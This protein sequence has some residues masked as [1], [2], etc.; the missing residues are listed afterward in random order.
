[1]P[2]TQSEAVC[3]V[4]APSCTIFVD[5]FGIMIWVKNG[6]PAGSL[7]CRL[8]LFASFQ[9]FSLATPLAPEP[10]SIGWRTPHSTD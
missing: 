8:S 1:M 9:A 3:E 2:T 6:E 5:F 10:R 7:S 4:S